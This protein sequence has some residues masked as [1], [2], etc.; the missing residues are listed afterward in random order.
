[1][2][3]TRIGPNK[4]LKACPTAMSLNWLLECANPEHLTVAMA[5][6]K[7]AQADDMQNWFHLKLSGAPRGSQHRA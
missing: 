3:V 4:L 1:M 5:L 7:E 6:I 2:A